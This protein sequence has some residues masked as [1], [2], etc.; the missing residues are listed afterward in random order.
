MNEKRA[1]WA[2]TAVEEHLRQYA[3]P[4]EPMYQN[5]TD[6]LCNLQHL[7]DRHELD[8]DDL[9]RVAKDHYGSE[10]TEDG[11][12]LGTGK[13][14]KWAEAS[15][16]HISRDSTRKLSPV[17]RRD[18]G[19]I[20]K[21]FVEEMVKSGFEIT[22]EYNKGPYTGPAVEVGNAF[23]AMR[24]RTHLTGIEFR[25]VKTEGRFVFYPKI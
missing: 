20:I 19:T 5:V 12:G 6:L 4:D 22:D 24:V 8:F 16:E 9:L 21:K 17:F 23:D 25:E 13:K 3:N 14:L 2:E 15:S 10:I 1:D 18:A 11:P 7:C